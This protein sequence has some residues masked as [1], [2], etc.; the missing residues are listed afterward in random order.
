MVKL[1]QSG[2]LEKKTP[3]EIVGTLA[4]FILDAVPAE[5]CEGLRPI[6][7]E[8]QELLDVSG[9]QGRR[10]DRDCGI[11]SPPTF[12][13]THPFWANILAAWMDGTEAAV[14]VNEYGVYEGNLMR[15]LLKTANLVEEWLAMATF[16]GDLEMLDHMKD[17]RGQLLRG[18]AQPES[19][20]LR[21]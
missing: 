7:G 9:N 2:V 16:C 19:L 21:L 18:I 14:L 13:S 3:A 6:V 20:Y 12:W 5:G 17:V 11:A 1:Y 4:S 10:I 15:S 8:A